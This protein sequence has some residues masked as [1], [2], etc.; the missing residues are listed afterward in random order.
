MLTTP[1]LQ[2]YLRQIMLPEIGITG[3]EKL[4]QAKVLVIGAGGLGCP[5]LQYLTA[6]GVGTIGIADHDAVDITNLQRQILYNTHDIGHL[7]ANIAAT[8]LSALNP[9]VQL[10]PIIEKVSEHNAAE[11]MAAYDLIIDGSDNFPTRYLVNDTCVALNKP[12]ISGSVLG[13]EAQ[14]SVY[15]YKGG[16]TYRCLF[17]EPSATANC[18][19]NGV[20]GILPGIAGAYMANEAVKVICQAG[21]VLSGLLLVINSLTNSNQLFQFTRQQPASVQVLPG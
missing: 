6:A 1:E 10:Q 2:R 21:T 15:N 3:Q 4:Q 18:A 9:F 14:V 20:L 7:K 17:P 16:P 13:F 5:V 19:E 12:F 8:R 11:L